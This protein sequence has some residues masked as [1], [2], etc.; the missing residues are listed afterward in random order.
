MLVYTSPIQPKNNVLIFVIINFS[1]SVQREWFLFR[2]ERAKTMLILTISKYG[3]DKTI[4]LTRSLLVVLSIL[5]CL[6]M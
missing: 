4:R 3:C 6:I 1:L 5:L 2:D